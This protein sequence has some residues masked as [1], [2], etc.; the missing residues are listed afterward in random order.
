MK[1]IW[2]FVGLIL[3]SM[4]LILVVSGISLLSSGE[5]HKTVLGHTYP[6]L[7][8]GSFMT[9]SGLI[10]ILANRKKTV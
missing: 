2:Y 9:L 10:F 6:D 4:G 8:W 5:T 1:P 7:W 3:V